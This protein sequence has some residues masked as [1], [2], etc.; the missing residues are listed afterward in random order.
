MERVPQDRESTPNPDG[1][2][3]TEPGPELRVRATEGFDG[4]LGVVWTELSS[5]HAT[6]EVPVR[7]ELTQPAGLVHG[8]VY[9]TL[10]ETVASTATAVALGAGAGSVLGLSNL[11]S[12][13]RPVADGTIHADAVSKHSGRTTWVWEV[14]MKDDDGRLCAVSRVTV[15]V[16]P[17]PASPSAGNP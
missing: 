11:T 14:E 10:A 1:R 3:P 16:R 2:L 17:A 8:G 7:P 6:A 13:L 5:E 4:L 15:A 9:A 12:Y